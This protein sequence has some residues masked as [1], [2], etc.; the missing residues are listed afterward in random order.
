MQIREDRAEL[1]RPRTVTIYEGRVASVHTDADPLVYKWGN[2]YRNADRLPLIAAQLPG[3]NVT[4]LHPAEHYNHGGNAKSIGTIK[5]ARVD[6]D[7]VIAEFEITDED[8]LNEIRLGTRDLSLGYDARCDE[9]GYQIDIT[10]DH[11]ALVPVGR[12]TSCELRADCG[13]ESTE[14]I[15]EPVVVDEVK[16]RTDVASPIIACTC[17]DDAVTP[18][19][20][21]IQEACQTSGMEELQKQLDEA[22]AKAS[23]AEADLTAANAA[24]DAEKLRA[25]NAETAKNEFE[26]VAQNAT[27]DAEKAQAD[28]VAATEAAKVEADKVRADAAESVTVAVA[29]AIADAKART[30]LEATASSVLGAQD[31]DGNVIDRTA[32]TNKEIKV[33][34]IKHVDG[35]DFDDSKPDLFIDGVFAGAVKR[36]G[37][38]ATALAETRQ[39]IEAVRQ[40]GVAV[41]TTPNSENAADAA[42][43]KRYSNAWMDSTKKDN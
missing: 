13:C 21:S 29:T 5:S 8:A 22:L 39:V 19:L 23:K 2:E 15:V 12:C 26:V 6:G 25:D 10:V 37:K 35:D 41:V 43:R 24:R 28:L 33:A 7:H 42:L 36:H 30:V 31:K 4:M 20:D 32:L 18:T 3:K 14:T 17:H 40:D 16:V 1:A 9:S 38:G 11:L 34:V 27:K